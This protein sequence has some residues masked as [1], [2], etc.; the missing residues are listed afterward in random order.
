LLKLENV[1]K[2]HGVLRGDDG[3]ATIIFAFLSEPATFC[4]PSWFNFK[5]ANVDFGGFYFP[6]DRGIVICN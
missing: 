5:S 4:T 1:L 3:R 6:K 2:S